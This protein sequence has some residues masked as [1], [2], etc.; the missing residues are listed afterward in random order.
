FVLHGKEAAGEQPLF[1]AKSITVGLKIVSIL[2]RDI[3]I[4]SLVLEKPH[5]HVIVLPDGTTNLPEPKI[6][7]HSDQSFTAR[8]LDLAIKKCVVRDGLLEFNDRKIPLNLEADRLNVDIVYEAAAPRY[9]GSIRSDRV[10]LEAPRAQPASFGFET[11]FALEKDRVTISKSRVSMSASS[12]ELAGTVEHLSSPAGAFDVRAKVLPA[13][14]KQLVKLPIGAPGTISFNGNATFRSNPLNY[15]LDGTLSGRGLSYRDARVNVGNAVVD[16]KLR[17]TPEELR[18]SGVR[19]RAMGGTF[20]GDLQLRRMTDLQING[21]IGGFQIRDLAKIGARKDVPWNGAVSG[22]LHVEGKLVNGGVRDITSQARLDITPAASG[23]IPVSG[24]V[25]INVDINYDQR[26]STVRLGDSRLSAGS[27]QAEISGTLGQS[28]HVVLTTQNLNDLLPVFTLAGETPPEK[29]PVE[30]KNGTAHLDATVDGPL[31]DPMIAGRLEALHISVKNHAIDSIDT[32]FAV[33][34]SS[35]NVKSMEVRQGAARAR[36]SGHLGLNQ[37]KP[38]GASPVDASLTLKG[39]ALESLLAEFD[40]KLPVSGVLSATADVHGTFA[41]PSAD[42]RAT[43]TGVTA[44]GEKIGTATAEIRYSPETLDLVRGRMEEDGARIDVSGKFD[45]PRNDLRNGEAQFQIASAGIRLARIEHVRQVRQDVDGQVQLQANGTA[46]LVNGIAQLETLKSE[47][48]LHNFSIAG[49]RLGDATLAAN[50]KG[51]EL[52]ATVNGTIG[53]TKI[54]GHGEWTLEGD[55]P[56]QGSLE[57]S[58]TTF[59][60]LQRLTARAT[61]IERLPFEG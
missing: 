37:W 39:A 11:E 38:A 33:M 10:S 8:I 57:F 26:T 18:A 20:D 59:A 5:G 35:L 23:G 56:G 22:P 46:R 43:A 45:H 12:V 3:D 40:R 17:V 29:L 41:N 1:R 28:L 24:S 27:T 16:A 48:D 13:D 7:W 32:N 6:P 51:A 2:K 31:R 53:E 30:L 36:G 47:T 21:K 14:I 60:E 19:L 25:D 34:A 55:Y 9:R 61:K 4:A 52:T 58:R 50:T 42:I 44:Y 15:Q 49:E 54:Q